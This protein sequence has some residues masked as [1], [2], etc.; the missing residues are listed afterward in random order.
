M[1]IQCHHV[2][3]LGIFATSSAEIAQIKLYEL[4]EELPE[5]YCASKAMNS[6]SGS[7]GMHTL[8]LLQS[9][10]INRNNY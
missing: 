5:R 7:P 9:E 6:F 4:H 3:R 2:G 8:R 1:C 10:I